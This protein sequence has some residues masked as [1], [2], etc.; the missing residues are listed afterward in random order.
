M[1]VAGRIEIR[2]IGLRRIGDGFVTSMMWDAGG[3]PFKT[4]GAT[5]VTINSADAGTAKFTNEWSQLVTGGLVSNITSW[6]DQWYTAL[7][8][9]TLATLV[10][11]AW[12]PGDFESS[13]AASSGDWRVAPMPTYTAGGPAATA[14]NGGSSYAVMKGSKNAL[15]AGAKRANAM[16][17]SEH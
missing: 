5:D 7:G 15:V 6:T 13:V 10:T 17:E 4:T 12:M 2:R 3:Q 1:E 11:G 9:G 8:N 16:I 14:E